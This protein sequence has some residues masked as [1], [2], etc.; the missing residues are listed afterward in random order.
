MRFNIYH[1]NYLTQHSFYYSQEGFV[2]PDLVSL[3]VSDLQE[4]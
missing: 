2:S 4:S 1:F 3:S